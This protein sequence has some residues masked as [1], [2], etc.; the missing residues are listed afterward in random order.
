MWLGAALGTFLLVTDLIHAPLLEGKR[1]YHWLGSR[2]WH[3]KWFAQGH[4][5]SKNWIKIWLIPKSICSF[6][7]TGQ[8]PPEND[9]KHIT[10][11]KG[12]EVKTIICRVKTLEHSPLQEI[13]HATTLIPATE[14][15][16]HLF[17]PQNNLIISS[18]Q[19]TR[20]YRSSALNCSPV[21]LKS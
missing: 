21:T 7:S 20:N 16:S 19:R 13:N 4:T 11:E 12:E 1:Y 15:T 18:H 10:N 17:I 3:V 8:P 14:L 9:P 2:V 6:H 5:P